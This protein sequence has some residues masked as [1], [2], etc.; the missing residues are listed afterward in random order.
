[1]VFVANYLA[2]DR[3][4]ANIDDEVT[5]ADLE[6]WTEHFVNQA[7]EAISAILGRTD[8]GRRARPCAPH[9][10]HESHAASPT[11]ASAPLRAGA[12]AARP[13]ADR[14]ISYGAAWIAYDGRRL[15]LAKPFE[16]TLADDHPAELLPAG[17][18]LP[19]DEDNEF[20]RFPVHCVDPRDGRARFILT[21]PVDPR[22]AQP[23]DPRRMY[24]TLLLPVDDELG[25]LASDSTSTWL[26]TRISWSQ[27]R[28]ALSCRGR[29]RPA[30][31]T[32]SSSV[33]SSGRSNERRRQAPIDVVHHSRR[34][35]PP[36]RASQSSG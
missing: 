15:Q 31:Y 10:G 27:S 13:D 32:N 29:W 28:R 3:D 7:V 14:L 19:V 24:G 20:A 22:R 26:W 4:A 21:R 1:M 8:T 17:T 18:N 16:L 25:P 9:G 34:R 35:R 6:H 30:R 33:S 12:S 36:S 2:I 23:L 5:K 11:H